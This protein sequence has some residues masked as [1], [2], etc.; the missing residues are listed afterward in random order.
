MGGLAGFQTPTTSIAKGILGV[1]LLGASVTT[2]FG[3]QSVG[4]TG[5]GY[6]RQFREGIVAGKS[7]D[8]ELGQFSRQ[9]RDLGMSLT[10]FRAKVQQVST[11]LGTSVAEHVRFLS[12]SMREIQGFTDSVQGAS[13]ATRAL[14]SAQSTITTARMT[15]MNLSQYGQSVDAMRASGLI[16]GVG[17]RQGYGTTEI[18]FNQQFSRAIGMGGFGA[19]RDQALQSAATSAI[20][21]VGAGG[22]MI[23]VANSIGTQTSI[24][25]AARGF[26]TPTGTKIDPDASMLSF[27]S[28]AIQKFDTSL[29]ARGAM[30]SMQIPG[31]MIAGYDMA[32]APLLK[33]TTDELDSVTSE[34]ARYTTPDQL[35]DN[36]PRIDELNSRR[37]K[38]EDQQKTYSNM[39]NPMAV[40]R[41]F[42]SGDANLQGELVASMAKSFTGKNDSG[43]LDDSLDNDM[44][45]GIISQ[46]MGIEGG[47]PAVQAILKARQARLDPKN[48]EAANRT[49]ALTN[50]M[51][52]SEGYKSIGT[53]FDSRSG[54]DGNSQEYARQIQTSLEPILSSAATGQDYDT[55]LASWI[56]SSGLY[57]DEKTKNELKSKVSRTRNVA[58]FA[59][60][61]ELETRNKQLGMISEFSSD[62]TRIENGTVRPNYAGQNILTSSQVQ[63]GELYKSFEMIGGAANTFVQN[64]RAGGQSLSETMANFN[65]TIA[66][67]GDALSAMLRVVGSYIDLG[68]KGAFGASAG[69]AT[70][71]VDALNPIGGTLQGIITNPDALLTAG[72]DEL[73]KIIKRGASGTDEPRI[74]INAGGP[75]AF[76][77][78]VYG[79]LTA[80]MQSAENLIPQQRSWSMASTLD[81][82]HSFVPKY[83]SYVMST[84]DVRSSM[85]DVNFNRDEIARMNNTQGMEWYQDKAILASSAS[86]RDNQ[87]PVDPRLMFA[88]MKEESHFDV[89]A[90]NTE[91]FATGLFQILA[92]S[93]EARTP[94]LDPKTN[95]LMAGK[96]MAEK[97]NMFDKVTYDEQGNELKISSDPYTQENVMGKDRTFDAIDKALLLWHGSYAKKGKPG[98]S[99]PKPAETLAWL[100]RIREAYSAQGGKRPGSKVTKDDLFW[101][102]DE[103]NDYFT[104]SYPRRASGGQILGRSPVIVGEKGPEVYVPGGSGSILPND[105][106]ANMNASGGQSQQ[107]ISHK[108]TI[109][110]VNSS[111]DSLGSTEIDLMAAISH[112]AILNPAKQIVRSS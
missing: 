2:S 79:G 40:N 75:R 76:G 66:S 14:D 72:K 112:Y 36:A 8:Y 91:S 87:R 41:A 78:P 98:F 27:G 59:G 44:I 22:R 92:D 81:K 7:N 89:N 26:T 12:S 58:E 20:S 11:G 86:R 110:F 32:R 46:Q 77:G 4:L 105:F 33:K 52:T 47:V 106:L 23:D 84:K 73:A 19:L 35:R 30:G 64:F 100:D 69:A 68:V 34:L 39:T 24:F 45:F 43:L 97:I 21:Q 57:S 3:A 109:E 42:R 25:Q 13:R 63:G 108:M 9:I 29:V 31:M 38:L 85:N 37:K 93:E 71:A 103:A 48:I 1:P 70:G 90:K 80:S 16:G 94:L 53:M 51:G 102:E 96:I 107:S 10:D 95:T 56:D 83:D 101:D 62:S 65:R 18:G 99:D 6:E 50:G 88:L 82:E 49:K 17:Q 55:E 15:G 54:I 67:G 74:D 28:Q 5:E 104:A 60:M 61:N 111:G